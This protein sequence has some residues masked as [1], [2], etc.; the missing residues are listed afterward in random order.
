MTISTLSH[1][2]LMPHLKGDGYAH[3]KNMQIQLPAARKA[4]KRSKGERDVD[5][6]MVAA[7]LLHRL[8]AAER[9]E[10]PGR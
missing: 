9:A 2:A 10:R 6:D 7:P 8:N 3:A 4:N 5:T 1:F